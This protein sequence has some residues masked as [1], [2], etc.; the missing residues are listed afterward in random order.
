MR[1]NISLFSSLND[2]VRRLKAI[3][4]IFLR[5]ADLIVIENKINNE[6]TKNWII[7]F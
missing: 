3:C 5:L 7:L 2:K 4:S 6:R 1:S